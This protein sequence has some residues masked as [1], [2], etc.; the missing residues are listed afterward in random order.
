MRRVTI[1]V[2][3]L[4]GVA[5]GRA[6]R[7]TNALEE[8]M[9]MGEQWAQENLDD[10]VLRLFDNVDREAV[11]QFLASVQQKF[12]SE[13]V[14]D[15]AQLQQAATAVLPLLKAHES[16]RPYAIW[17]ETRLDYFQVAE[18]IRVTT[19]PPKRVP[20]PAPEL[21]RK[22]W[23]GQLNRRPA[24]A[25]ADR[26]AARLKPVFVAHKVPAELVWV[27]EVESSFNPGARS[28]VGAVGLFQ[29]MPATARQLGLALRPDERLD[30]EKNAGAAAKY[31]KYLHDKSKDWP[32]ALAMYNAG[33]GR[34]QAL[35]DRA[36]PKTFD[37]I[38]TRLPAETQ[39]YVPKINATLLRREGV[40]LAELIM[41][42]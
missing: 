12:Q 33:E 10:D 20:N 34:V 26:L 3:L 9:Q 40:T 42:K 41:P 7:S 4:A 37:R 25:G 31:L 28:P 2:L 11:Q 6:Q 35:L 23:E 29:L 16:T 30:P 14:V 21:Q 5:G 18:E 24:P 27:A 15:L 13:Y 17:L 36:Q 38:A 32:L 19:S 1:L 22:L 39:M 8:L